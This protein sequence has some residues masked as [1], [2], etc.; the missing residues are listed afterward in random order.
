MTREERQREAAHWR[1]LAEDFI[2]RRSLRCECGCRRVYGICHR[3][4]LLVPVSQ[5]G[6]M[7]RR[8][9]AYLCGRLYAYRTKINSDAA[10]AL[11]CLWLACEAEAGV[12]P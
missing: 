8:L 11:A 12:W 3:I 5:S 6:G 1:K 7:R 2:E 4:D 9:N 10:R